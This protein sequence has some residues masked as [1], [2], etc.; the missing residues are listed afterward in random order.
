MNIY[1]GG[2][3][4]IAAEPPIE[5]ETER[6]CRE[7]GVNQPIGKYKPVPHGGRS[8][9]CSKCTSRKGR[10]NKQAIVENATASKAWIIGELIKQ[11]NKTNKQSEKIRCLETLAKLMPEEAATRL[12]DPAVVASLIAA[13]K[14]KKQPE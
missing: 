13:M 9:V 12:D 11:Y 3:K 4:P 10:E 2:L 5:E 6:I 14:K 7:C 8:Q 1:E